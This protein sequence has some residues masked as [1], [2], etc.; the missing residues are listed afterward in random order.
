MKNLVLTAATSLDIN[1]VKRFVISF[2]KYNTVDDLVLIVSEDDIKTFEPELKGYN[3]KY[4]LFEAYKAL[5]TSIINSRYYKYLDFIYDNNEYNQILLTDCRDVFF[6]DNPFNHI[7]YDSIYFIEEER[8]Q[9]IGTN[10]YNSKWIRWCYD[11]HIFSKLQNKP[12]L[13]AG[14]VI[15]SKQNIITYIKHMIYKIT[16]M[17]KDYDHVRYL[18]VFD[19]GISNYL[20]YESS[21]LFKNP[22]I[23]QNGT[24]ALHS[25]L[26]LRCCKEKIRMNDGCIYYNDNKPV[27]VHQYTVSDNITEYVDHIIESY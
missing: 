13:C 26:T 20:L 2:R 12:I 7:T 17:L 14:V 23:L 10:E 8:C 19:Q 27:I 4:T 6:Q 21:N 11:S 1:E 3:V 15:G 5:K 25:S 18:G 16:K 9:T 24:L 22:T